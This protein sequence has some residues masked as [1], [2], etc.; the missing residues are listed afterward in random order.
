M[1]YFYFHYFQ[2]FGY[3]HT[4]TIYLINIFDEELIQHLHTEVEL[5]HFVQLKK[6]ELTKQKHQQQQL[7]M[8]EV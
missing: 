1:N 2:H 5:L 4:E 7:I 3:L 6:V 8:E